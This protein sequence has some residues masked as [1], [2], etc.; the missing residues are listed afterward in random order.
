MSKLIP[1]IAVICGILLFSGGY[2]A[3]FTIAAVLSLPLLVWLTYRP[4]ESPVLLFVMFYQWLQVCTKSFHASFLGMDVRDMLPWAPIDQALWLGLF[5]V[6]SVAGGLK[7]ATFNSRSDLSQRAQAQALHVNLLDLFKLH[8]GAL[9]AVEFL[10]RVAA[11]GGLSQAVHAIGYLRFVTLFVF[12]Y[13]V[14]VKERGYGWLILLLGAEIAYSFGGFF[15]GFR[16]PLFVTLLAVASVPIGRSIRRPVLLG[17]LA[18]ATLYIAVLWQ[19]IKPEY[20]EYVSQDSGAQAVLVDR[21]AQIAK[22]SEL[23]AEVNVDVLERGAEA[24]AVRF[25]YVDMLAYTLGHVPDARPHT[26][27]QLMADA[28][29]HVLMPRMFFPDKAIIDDTAFT[30]EYTGLAMHSVEATSISIGYVGDAYIDFGV[31]GM[32]IWLFVLGVLLG[33]AYRWMSTYKVL[34]PLLRVALVTMLFLA[35][36]EFGTPLSKVFGGFLVP[37]I[38]ASLLIVF[39]EARVVRMLGKHFGLARANQTAAAP[40]TVDAVPES[41]QQ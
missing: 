2:N 19:A 27:G 5:G 38:L 31:P 8:M 25:A 28:F 12:T 41:R 18:V 40:T 23:V 10:A 29:A 3:S 36:G 9:L 26:D 34:N 16:L 13:V 17:V 35:I 21:E 32:F 22:L 20:R 33:L 37:F 15:A 24:F 14:V 7:L 11:Y 4:Q 30:K 39:G 1:L 6:L